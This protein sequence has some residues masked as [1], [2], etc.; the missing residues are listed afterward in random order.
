MLSKCLLSD[1]TNEQESECL[2]RERAS[3]K[4][5][6]GFRKGS[7]EKHSPDIYSPQASQF[8]F[9][10]QIGA[11]LTLVSVY[12]QGSLEAAWKLIQYL[13]ETICL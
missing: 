11:P 12:L 3:V 10:G 6:S 8:W 9:A 4:E 13:E 5:I 7:W 1:F 2:K